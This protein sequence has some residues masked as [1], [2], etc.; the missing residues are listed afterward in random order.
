MLA[1][2]SGRRG[3]L[4][5]FM[6]DEGDERM[7]LKIA[8]ALSIASLLFCGAGFAEDQDFDGWRGEIG[9][10]NL[11]PKGVLGDRYSSEWSPSLFLEHS[12]NKYLGMSFAL[13]YANFHRDKGPGAEDLMVID[14]LMDGLLQY[15]IENWQP[16]IEMGMGLYFWHADSAWWANGEKMDDVNLGFNYGFGI[17][18]MPMPSLGLTAK[19]LNHRVKFEGADSSS[20]WIDYFLG[21]RVEF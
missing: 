11:S 9:I 18:Y 20:H 10:A 21:V 1:G 14:G 8:C 16:F 6:C 5:I 2:L 17:S 19:M 4:L 7:N 15:Q 13:E 3:S 12:F